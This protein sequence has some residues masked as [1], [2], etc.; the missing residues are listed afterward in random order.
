MTILDPQL[1]PL[2]FLAVAGLVRTL[3]T[4]PIRPAMTAVTIQTMGGVQTMQY[5]VAATKAMVLKRTVALAAKLTLPQRQ[6]LLH[7]RCV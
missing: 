5:Q 4:G 1:L 2:G 7:Q 3:L 6:Q